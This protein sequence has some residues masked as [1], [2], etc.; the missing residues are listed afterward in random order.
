[1]L[2]TRDILILVAAG[3]VGALAEATQLWLLLLATRHFHLADIGSTSLPLIVGDV[4]GIAV[5]TPLVLRLVTRLERMPILA[6]AALGELLLLLIAILLILYV[7]VRPPGPLGQSLF[8]LLFMPVV[9]AAVRHGIDGACAA[10][11][12]SQI[13]LV[14]FLHW[15]GFE[16]SRF[17]EYQVLMLVLTLTGLIVG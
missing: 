6:T 12:I 9:I 1:L 4:I 13:G 15:H 2:R 10:L 17:T 8:Y 16:L 11:A 3:L 7:V 14:A 5:V